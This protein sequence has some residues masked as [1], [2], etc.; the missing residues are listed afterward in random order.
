M[1]YEREREQIEWLTLPPQ[2]GRRDIYSPREKTSRLGNSSDP[3]RR[4]GPPTGMARRAN[5]RTKTLANFLHHIRL[6]RL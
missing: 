6:G 4:Q 5:Q 2:G 3:N 1:E